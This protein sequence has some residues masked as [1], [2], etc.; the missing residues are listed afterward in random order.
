MREVLVDTN[1]LVRFITGE[2][3]SQAE[4]AKKLMLE[5]E[6]GSARIT[7]VPLVVAEVVFVLT[8]RVYGFPPV[9]VRDALILLLESPSIHVI[10]RDVLLQA[11]HTFVKKKVDFVDAYVAS[12]AA[13]KGCE[14]AT[15]DQDF[16]KFSNLKV[17]NLDNT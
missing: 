13:S 17:F 8:G 2:P 10:E 11:L 5:A 15:F 7:I 6:S 9:S 4:I 12:M 1:F 16:R 3:L 14:V